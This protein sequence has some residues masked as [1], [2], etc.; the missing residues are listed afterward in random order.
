MRNLESHASP[1]QWGDRQLLG[2]EVLEVPTGLRCSLVSAKLGPHSKGTLMAWVRHQTSWE[3]EWRVLSLSPQ[4][5]GIK[6]PHRQIT[7]ALPTS[8][9]P[10]VELDSVGVR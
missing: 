10:D 3:T 9:S 1:K 2:G 4:R 6:L 5:A 7:I 8:V